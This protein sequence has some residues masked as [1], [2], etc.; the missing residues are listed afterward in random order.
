M[1]LQYVRLHIS[2][3]VSPCACQFVKLQLW[4]QHMSVYYASSPDACTHKYREWW[5]E[6]KSSRHS[7]HSGSDETFPSLSGGL[8]PLM[9]GEDRSPLLAATG[10]RGG[11]GK[12]MAAWL[13]KGEDEGR[14]GEMEVEREAK[15]KRNRKGWKSGRNRG[16]LACLSFGFNKS[17]NKR[18]C[19]RNSVSS[20]FHHSSLNNS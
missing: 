1:K 6:R 3:P 10:L 18:I 15:R 4:G 17:F 16:L 20:S 14:A 19:I 9:G 13:N 5:R 2:L 8:L 11:E 12:L 7:E